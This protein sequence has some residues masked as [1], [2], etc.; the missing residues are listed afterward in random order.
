[1]SSAWLEWNGRL[2]F[3]EYRRVPHEPQS[4]VTRLIDGI[5]RRFPGSAHFI[6]RSRIYLDYEPTELCRGMMIVC[7]KRFTRVKEVPADIRQRSTRVDAA[8]ELA[9]SQVS[10]LNDSSLIGTPSNVRAEQHRS[11]EAWLLD[12]HGR[13]LAWGINT[14]GRNRTSHAEMNLLRNWWARTRQAVPCGSRLVSTLEPCPMCAGALVE[15]L[16]SQTNFTVEYL[17]PDC[18]TAVRRSVL[19]NSPLAHNCQLLNHPKHEQDS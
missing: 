7:A 12:A 15:C 19:R 18:G 8:L 13:L 2:F 16:E 14:A 5:W 10:V 9:L 11:I 1:M 4:A 6:L 3:S 17:E